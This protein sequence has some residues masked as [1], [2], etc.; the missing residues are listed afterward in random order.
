MSRQQADSIGP[1][2][3]GGEGAYWKIFWWKAEKRRFKNKMSWSRNSPV[4]G[5]KQYSGS[6]S[7]PCFGWS[8]SDTYID[9]RV[10]GAER[11]RWSR[12]EAE[13]TCQCSIGPPKGPA[14]GP[15]RVMY[16]DIKDSF[17]PTPSVKLP[18]SHPPHQPKSHPIMVSVTWQGPRRS[19]LSHCSL[20][21]LFSLVPFSCSSPVP[22]DE[23]FQK[24]LYLLLLLTWTISSATYL[25]S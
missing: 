19:L 13:G 15:R 12:G 4:R 7:V 10:T 22:L 1:E 3:W 16:Y 8:D 18:A 25:C 9:T 14:P 17:S 6:K 5:T 23:V 11:E 24:P 21:P 20:F 2:G